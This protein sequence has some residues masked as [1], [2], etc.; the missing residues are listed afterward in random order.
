MELVQYMTLSGVYLLGCLH[1]TIAIQEV[2]LEN[3]AHNGETL[4]CLQLRGKGEQARVFNMDV[5]I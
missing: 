2:P 3:R 4:S 1:F 5:L